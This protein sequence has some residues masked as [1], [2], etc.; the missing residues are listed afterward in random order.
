MATA[1][2][3]FFYL[4]HCLAVSL[5]QSISTSTPVPPLQWLN[6]TPLLQGATAPPSLRNVA[7]GYDE[8]SRQLVVFGGEADGGFVQSQTYLLNMD[9]LTWS[10]PS[11]PANL[12]STPPARSA[13]ISGIDIAASNRHAFIIIGGKG[14]NSVA[15]SDVWAFDFTNQFWSQISPTNAGPTPR[16]GASGGIDLQTPPIQ[17]PVLPGPNNT[18]YLAGGFDGRTI[19]PLSDTWRLNVSGTLSANLPNSVMATWE[20]IPVA[21]TLPSKVRQGGSII[22]QRIISTGGCSTAIDENNGDPS[23]AQQDSYVLDIARRSSISPGPCP[24][25]RL[26]PVLV[27]NAN[28]YST[29]FASQVFLA[30][31]TFN[32]S[33]WS[34]GNGLSRGEIDVLDV[35]TGSWSRILPSGDPG[36]TGE[37]AYP[38]PR[39]GAA[40]FSY[41]RALVGAS[42]N[43]IS[44]TI[45]FGGRDSSG[46]YL[47]DMWLLRSYRDSL[48]SSSTHWSGYGSGHLQSGIN[49]NGSGVVVEY[50]TECSSLKDFTTPSNN[51]TATNPGEAQP[52]GATYRT[53]AAHI[54]LSAFSSIVLLASYSSL[55]RCP[56]NFSLNP[57]SGLRPLLMS[58]F[59]IIGYII[60]LAGLVISFTSLKVTNS[61]DASTKKHLSTPHGRAGLAFFLCLYVLAPILY[62]TSLLLARNRRRVQSDDASGTTELQ[63]TTSNGTY[64]KPGSTTPQTPSINGLY[65]PP[66]SPRPRTQSATHPRR[67]SEALSTDGEESM[68]SGPPRRGFEVLNRPGRALRSA[69]AGSSLHPPTQMQP[70]SS[71]SL[72][73]IDWLLRRRSLNAVGELDYAL[74]M[75]HNAQRNSAVTTASLVPASAQSPSTRDPPSF[76]LV[77]AYLVAQAG[78]IGIFVIT[79]IAMWRHGP[80]VGFI[81]FLVGITL[82]YITILWSPHRLPV[83]DYL[84]SF[85]CLRRRRGLNSSPIPG[86]APVTAPQ[87]PPVQPAPHVQGPYLHA[88]PF[89]RTRSNFGVGGSGRPV[90]PEEN[91]DDDDDMDENARQR[92][93]EDE[94]SRRDV[95]IV[96]TP[97][98]KLWVVNPS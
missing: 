3:L 98:R 17:D 77:A 88:P 78:F 2:I 70:S 33:L 50:L 15:L 55:R 37:V 14:S 67:S 20:K 52:H 8:A 28:V 81:L 43:G 95:S 41:E 46:K 63:R 6:L 57:R 69:D 19:Y 39:E 38:A 74:S 83:E 22:G 4:S 59:I 79:L 11:P 34:D 36:S 21:Q 60:G 7:L 87:S 82:F 94:M 71:R 51:E 10:I 29:N 53:T 44:D 27:P 9:T 45:I 58:I 97:K 65:S 56:T 85:S 84:F 73:E 24:A 1:L 31:G 48:T 40:S 54:A 68:S 62:F 42:R 32:N 12:A 25:P 89:S 49:A 64:E 35:N 61:T 30:L 91:E 26:D 23:C 92:M 96:T 16:W 90:S 72:G 86:P 75:A 80:L 76:L 66:A 18:F 5:G 47:S 93:I 13:A